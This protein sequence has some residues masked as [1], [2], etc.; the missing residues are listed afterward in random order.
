MPVDVGKSLNVATERNS[1]KLLA[2]ASVHLRKTL[3]TVSTGSSSMK[4]LALVFVLSNGT[5]AVPEPHFGAT[6][7]AHAANSSQRVDV[8]EEDGATRDASAL[9]IPQQ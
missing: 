6:T 3:A 8:L 5:N 7:T 1:T 2:S 9:Q 4:T